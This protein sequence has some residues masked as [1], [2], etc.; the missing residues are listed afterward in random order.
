[1]YNFKK[2]R[3]EVGETEFSHRWFRRGGKFKKHCFI[4]LKVTFSSYKKKKLGG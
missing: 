2:S 1:M 3:N 4:F